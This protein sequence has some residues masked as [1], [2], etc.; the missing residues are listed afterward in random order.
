MDDVAKSGRTVLFVSHNMESIQRLCN[1]SI[2]LENGLINK[3]GN[4]NSIIEK[5]LKGTENKRNLKLEMRKDRSGNGDYKIKS[6]RT[7]SDGKETEGRIKIGEQVEFR[8]NVFKTSNETLNKKFH[9][10]LSKALV[11]S[12]NTKRPSFPSSLYFSIISIISR[13][14]EPINLPF[15]YAT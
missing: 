7:Y 12:R 2:L 15:I 9:S 6:V 8:I 11:K 1:K 13:T 4:T 5:Y 14:F 10:M 3:I